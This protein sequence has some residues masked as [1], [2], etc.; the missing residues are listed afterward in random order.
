MAGSRRSTWVL[1][2]DESHFVGAGLHS[3][4]T[5][6]SV[7]G[8]VWFCIKGVEPE[9]KIREQSAVGNVEFELN[10]SSLHEIDD[11]LPHVA[12]MQLLSVSE[13][14]DGWKGAFSGFIA[15]PGAQQPLQRANSWVQLCWGWNHTSTSWIW[16]PFWTKT[17]T[18][19]TRRSWVAFPNLNPWMNKTLFL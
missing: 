8:L 1:C 15:L 2:N 5:T 9:N 16:K 17:N 6:F 4:K 13:G 14:F 18:T 12:E 11:W 19:R 3:N 7:K 10:C